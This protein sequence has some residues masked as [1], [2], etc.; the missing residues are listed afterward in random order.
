[1]RKLFPILF[2]FFT[3]CF[4]PG[5]LIK[6]GYLASIDIKETGDFELQRF[7]TADSVDMFVNRYTE[8]ELN[9][10]EFISNAPPFYDFKN[11]GFYIYIE[12]QAL[13]R[14]K[15]GKEHWKVYDEKLDSS[16]F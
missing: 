4:G 14:R 8:I 12:K 2:L 9:T 5:Q 11:G 3:S 16:A 1:M 7:S 15:G 6:T 13:Y 10:S